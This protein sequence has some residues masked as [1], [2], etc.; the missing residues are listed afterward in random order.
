MNKQQ[1][2]Q[3]LIDEA[4]EWLEFDKP[5]KAL[6]IGKKLEKMQHSSGF[7]IQ[8]L[9]YRDLNKRK[10]AIKVLERGTRTVPDVWLLWQLLGNF[11]SEEGQFEKSFEV[12]EKGLKI[13]SGDYVSLNYNYVIALERS[14]SIQ[15]AKEKMSG[16]FSDKYFPG[17]VT[18]ELFILVLALHCSLLNKEKKYIEV[19]AFFDSQKS[20]VENHEIKCLPEVSSFYVEIA[21]AHFKLKQIK[22]ADSFLKKSVKLDKNNTDAQWLY[23]EMRIHESNKN[24]IHYRIMVHGKWHEAFEG[25]SDPPGFYTTYNLVAKD[26]AEAFDMIKYFEPD[27]VHESLTMEEVDVVDESIKEPKGVYGGGGYSFYYEGDE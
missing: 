20:K 24:L 15:K 6:K 7:E 9:A 2:V 4:F 13:P 25:D 19:I 8:A 16:I 10:K 21:T 5:K 14:G 12:F 22:D 27:K 11:Y 1:E 18:P 3:E 17:D 23:R 26:E